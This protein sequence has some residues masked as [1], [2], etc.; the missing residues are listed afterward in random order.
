MK[1]VVP[2]ALLLILLFAFPLVRSATAAEAP[3][4]VLS[5]GTN[6]RTELGIGT[7]DS[8]R[9]P[10]V[11]HGSSGLRSLSA[12]FGQAMAIGPNGR[13]MA[14]GDDGTGQS[15]GRYDDCCNTSVT[16]PRSLKV[17]AKSVVVGGHYNYAV[18]PDGS[19]VKWGGYKDGFR[20]VKGLSKV[21]TLA[22]GDGHF[23][24]LMKNGTVKSWGG[25]NKGQLGLGVVGSSVPRPRKIPGLSGVKAIAAGGFQSLA[26]MK[27]GT[28]KRWGSLALDAITH[29]RQPVPITVTGISSATAV[30]AGQ[31]HSMVLLADGS[32][33]TW[34]FNRQGMLGDGTLTG[35]IDPVQVTGI[36]NATAISAGDNHSLALLA[37]GTVRAWGANDLGQLGDGTLESAATPVETMALRGVTA[38]EAG[39]ATSYVIQD[40]TEPVATVKLRIDPAT[41][42][43]QQVNGSGVGYTIFTQQRY[44]VGAEVRYFADLDARYATFNGWSGLCSGTADCVATLSG[45]STL[46]WSY[47]LVDEYRVAPDTIIDLRHVKSKERLAGFAFGVKGHF[48]WVGLGF[49]CRLIDLSAAAAGDELEFTVCR[50]NGAVNKVYKGLKPGRYAFEVR[51]TN[52]FGIDA[53]PARAAFRIRP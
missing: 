25:N 35:S 32:V 33:K 24:A 2:F 18:R 38:I 44:P 5:W 47:R 17:K 27:D 50:K 15:S 12:G 1:S 7:D 6:D 42:Y 8:S 45:D 28:V 43:S 34:G 37:D 39:S 16:I 51:A 30:S 10:V 53:S 13:T 26:L 4:R 19:V 52:S 11:V 20:V 31:W 46:S 22:I 40:S 3:T 41:E 48:R 49:E 23:L 29:S 9:A 21:R 36:S 14:W